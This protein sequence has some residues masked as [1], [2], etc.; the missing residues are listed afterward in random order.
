MRLCHRKTKPTNLVGF[1]QHGGVQNA[2]I[3]QSLLNIL[4][5]IKYAEIGVKSFWTKMGITKP[6][7]W[8]TLR[9]AASFDSHTHTH[10]HTLESNGTCPG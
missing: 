2:C 1:S 9:T 10:T 7:I 3:A 4:T 5:Y 6:S 8:V